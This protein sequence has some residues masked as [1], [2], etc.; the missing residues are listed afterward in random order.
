MAWSNV[1]N[2]T[3]FDL[4]GRVLNFLSEKPL[5]FLFPVINQMY[6][7]SALAVQE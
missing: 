7:S 5:N 3:P 1:P 6:S 4:G 2:I